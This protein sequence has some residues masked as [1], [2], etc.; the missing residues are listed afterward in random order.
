MLSAKRI[1]RF[2][3]RHKVE[4]VHA[5]VARD[6]LTA[7]VAV[8][9]AK[10]VRLVLT[11]HVVFPMKPFHRFALRNVDAVI[12]VSPAVGEQL[13]KIF[14]SEKITMIPN[15]LDF[16]NRFQS[17]SL[18]LEFRDLHSIPPDEP[19]VV[20]L[21]ELRVLKGQ[22]DFVLAAAEVVK[23]IPNARFVI[24]GRDNTPDKKFR[25]ELK[26]LVRV[27]GLEEQFLWLD[28]LDDIAPLLAAA[29]VFVSP[30]HSES[31]GLAILDAMAAGCA[32]VATETDGAKELIGD[33]CELAPI[34][35][36]LALT[37]LICGLLE[38]D[39]RRSKLG[40]TLKR[41]ARE[42]YGLDRMVD[43][44]EVLYSNVTKLS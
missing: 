43:A 42:K 12:A 41:V 10:G 40:E 22:R 23:R 35:D 24:A 26:R 2:A 19:L 6:Y 34:K 15:G 13:K 5:H 39:E 11:R 30:S 17:N 32:V 7:S 8:R 33:F 3:E 9:G 36:P 44:T 37:S 28:W 31:F 18:G 29:D 38:D 1:A 21:G 14:A 4:L 20:T 27:L 25:R 16:D